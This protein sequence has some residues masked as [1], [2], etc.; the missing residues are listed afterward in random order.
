MGVSTHTNLPINIGYA[1]RLNLFRSI[2]DWNKRESKSKL[3][4][5]SGKKINGNTTKILK[6]FDNKFNFGLSIDQKN[7]KKSW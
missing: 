5:A 3:I 4:R 2:D 7:K 1:I 6:K